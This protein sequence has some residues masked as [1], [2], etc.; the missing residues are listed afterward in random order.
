MPL[1]HIHIQ[2]QS[3]IEYRLYLTLTLFLTVQTLNTQPF[4]NEITKVTIYVLHP[5]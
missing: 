5:E 1:W 4:G 3:N 2:K